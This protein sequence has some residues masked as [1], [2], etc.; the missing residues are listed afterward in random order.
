MK[1]KLKNF[2]EKN[3]RT[4]KTIGFISIGAVIGWICGEKIYN[5]GKQEGMD[6]GVDAVE[7]LMNKAIEKNPD[8]TIKEFTNQEFIDSLAKEIIESYN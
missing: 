7:L 3:K 4:I 8:I 2:Y 5:S 6:L 1:E